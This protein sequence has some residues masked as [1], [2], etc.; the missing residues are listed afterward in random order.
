MA[1]SL[2]V[3][4][5]N[6]RNKEHWGK[7]FFDGNGLY[8]DVSARTGKKV[9]KLAYRIAGS[10]PKKFTLGA[11]PELSLAQAREKALELKRQ[12][13][14]GIDPAQAQKE[15]KLSRLNFSTVAAEFLEKKKRRLRPAHMQSG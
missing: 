4:F 15:Q 1:A 10:N 14:S 11:Y 3:S 7:Q 9:F 2:S 8:V 13:A 12:I 6:S 5:L